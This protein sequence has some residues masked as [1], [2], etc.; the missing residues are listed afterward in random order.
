VAR[1]NADELL[2]DGSRR[3]KYADIETFASHAAVHFRSKKKPAGLGR[4]GGL[5]EVR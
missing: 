1:E 4:T 2:P 5:L 3:A